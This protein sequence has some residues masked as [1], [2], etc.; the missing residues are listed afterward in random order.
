MPRLFWSPSKASVNVGGLAKLLSNEY[1]HPVPEDRLQRAIQG[2]S[3]VIAAYTRNAALLGEEA[4]AVA[5][6]RTPLT[7]VGFARASTDGAFLGTI[8]NVIV[9]PGLRRR[10][11]GTELLRRLTHQLEMSDVTD[12][13]LVTP[14][15]LAKFF[16]QAEFGPDRMHSTFMQYNSDTVGTPLGSI[17]L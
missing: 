11:I 3:V 8:H 13:G 12:V 15:H 2:S 4:D 1:N 6:K 5:D 9:Y 10:G 14:P 7:M 17:V 16:F